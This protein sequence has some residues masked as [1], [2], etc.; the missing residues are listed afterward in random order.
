MRVGV[1][2]ET[3]AGRAPRGARAGGGAQAPVRARARGRR[4]RP[5][6]ATAPRSPTRPSQEAGAT[7][8]D[9]PRQVWDA[10][11]VV[12][13]RAAQRR[14]DRPPAPGGVLIGFLNPLD[15]DRHRRAPSPPPARRRSRWRR[16]RA[17]RAPSR[18]TRSPRRPRS[19]GYEGAL[20]AARRMTRFFPMLTT[21]AGTVPPAKV[22]VLGAGVAGLQAIATARRLGARV[23]ALRRPLCRQGA[24]QVARRPA[25]SSSK[26]RRTPR[27]RAA[28][29]ASSPTEEQE[30]QRG[31]ARRRHRRAPTP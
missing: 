4:R 7:I 5:A 30:A 27:P 24:D 15:R 14:G 16:S 17:S 20:M 31:D 28:T 9:D 3:A 19:R 13:G 1:P 21:A 2:K 29:R 26:A 18:W 10:D 8:A 25:S 23:T 12:Q 6:R 22:L 11:V